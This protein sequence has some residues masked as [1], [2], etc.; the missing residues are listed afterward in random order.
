MIKLSLRHAG[1][2]GM[3]RALEPAPHIKYAKAAA[4]TAFYRFAAETRDKLRSATPR[5]ATGNLKRATKAKSMA[6]GGAKVYISRDGSTSGRGYHSHIVEKGTKARR[7]KKGASRGT[8]PAANYQE[9]IL[10]QA[11]GDFDRSV[12][13]RLEA[14]L[15]A[16]LIAEIRKAR[17]K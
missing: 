5:G 12:V 14:A 13:K 16:R 9:P 10:Q 1:I 17:S 2:D 11:R 6:G 7:T 8:M 4:R 15:R 3:I